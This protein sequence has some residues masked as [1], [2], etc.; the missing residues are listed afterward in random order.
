VIWRG[1]CDYTYT[2]C[3]RCERKVPISDCSWCNGFLVC[4][5][6]GCFDR[7]IN[8][9]FEIREAKE[10]ARDREELV[11]DPKLVNPVDPLSQLENLPASSGTW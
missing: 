1:Y 7:V 5:I 2:T 10:V 8:G 11:P 3:Q 9:A 6:Y 4:H